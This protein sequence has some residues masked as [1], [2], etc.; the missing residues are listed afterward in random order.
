MPRHI[1]FEETPLKH[2]KRHRRKDRVN[3]R[4]QY[5][6][7]FRASPPLANYHYITKAASS[8]MRYGEFSTKLYNLSDIARIYDLAPSTVSRWYAKGM[9]PEPFTVQ[10]G[11]SRWG[12]QVPYYTKQQVFAI[13]MVL[14]DIY[15]Q[16]S[17]Q[18]RQDH[19]AHIEMMREGSYIAIERISYKACTPKSY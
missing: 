15:R 3:K 13:C 4:K 18:F 19:E 10:S 11:Q 6:H 7:G 5:G 8:S 14:N 17:R 16:C 9:L 12:K 1:W 2:N